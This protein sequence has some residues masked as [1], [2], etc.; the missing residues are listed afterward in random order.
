MAV[1]EKALWQAVSPLLDEL[2]DADESRRDARL[3][4][5]RATDPTLANELGALL[6]RQGTVETQQFLE[7]S[8]LDATGAA[9]LAG[10][11]IGSYTLERPLGA[12]GMGSVWLARRSDGHFEGHAAVKFLNLAL[13]A[14][15]AGRFR[16]EGSVLAR[17]A[18]PNIARLLDAGL[19]AGQPYLVLEY[20]DGEPIDRWC[21]THALGVRAR[22]RLFVEVLGA[23][24][25]AHNNLIL[26]RDLKPSNILICLYDGQPIPKVIDFG[27]AKAMHQPLT[28]HTLYTAH[29]AMIGTPLYMSPEQAEINNLDVDTRTDIY[30]LGVILYELLTGTTP[31]ETQRFKAAAWHEMLRLIKD[32]EPPRPSTRLSSGAVLPSVAAQRRLEPVKLTKLV[33]GELDWIVMKCLEKDRGRRYETANGLARDLGRYLHDEPV[34]AC[35]P[36]TGYRLRKF[37]RKHRA[38]LV[39]TGLQELDARLLKTHLATGERLL[40]TDR[41]SSIVI[42]LDDTARTQEVGD[43]LALRLRSASSEPLVLTDWRARAPFYGQVRALYSGVF[44]FLG[45]IVFVLVCLATSNTLLMSVMERVREFGTL[46]AI[47]TGRGQVALMVV[48]EALWLGVVGALVG[49]ARYPPL[50]RESITL[51]LA[52]SVIEHIGRDN[53]IYLRGERGPCDADGDYT[54]IRALAALLVPG[55]RLLVTVPFGRSEDHGW[56]VQYDLARLKNLVAASN[57]GVAE[58]EFFRYRDAWEGPLPPHALGD[59]SYGRGAVAAS[60]LACLALVR[61]RGP[62]VSLRRR[63][64]AWKTPFPI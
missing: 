51:V 11:N 16:R 19:L 36:S 56:F 57:L 22:L 35:P 6:A 58:V 54:S 28:E 13:L 29:G 43:A 30:A 47:G 48:L 7:G 34:E 53:G 59:C 41:V 55:G 39:T 2:L 62:L 8:A 10:R 26:H 3:G 38:G 25:H 24:T 40:G 32:E 37:V 60:G 27:L 49:D 5:I 45:G 63:L 50:R 20:I 44:W 31:L 46:L 17:L 42:G 4:Q 1:I 64:A 52:I 15:G 21:D 33:R 9:T 12:G 61:E 18:H 23:V 14:R